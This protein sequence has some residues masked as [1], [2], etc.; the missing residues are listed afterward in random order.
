MKSARVRASLSMAREA[1]MV[2]RMAFWRKDP[3]KRITAVDN[4]MTAT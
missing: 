3:S 4:V 1:R 2:V